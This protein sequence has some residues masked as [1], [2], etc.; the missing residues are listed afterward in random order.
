[1]GFSVGS[2]AKI[3]EVDDKG[4]YAKLKITISKKLKDKVPAQYICTY[5]GWV[6]CVGKAYQNRPMAGQKIK[7]TNCDVTNGFADRTTGEQ[8]FTNSPQCTIFEYELQSDSQ[9]NSY[10]PNAYGGG[11]GGFEP[12]EIASEDSLPF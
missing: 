1:M 11:M 3:K 12:I 2:Y 8:K 5:A 6:T 9:G 7:I 10:V 4:N